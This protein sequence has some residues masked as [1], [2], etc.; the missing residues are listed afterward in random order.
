MIKGVRG[1]EGKRKK[2]VEKIFK[3]IRVRIK[4]IG[5]KKIGGE[6]KNVGRCCR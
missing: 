6:M 4:I 3:A 1:R 5:I 2:A